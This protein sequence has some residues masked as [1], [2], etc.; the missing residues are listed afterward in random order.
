Q[1]IAESEGKPVGVPAEYDAFHYQH[2]MP[3]GMLSNFQAQL[4]AAGLSHKFEELLEECAAVRRELAWPI[5]ITPFSQFVG[6][7]AVMNIVHGER[8]AIVPDEVK[9]YALGYYGKLLGPVDP[10]ALD[11][12]VRNGSPKIPLIPPPLEPLVAKARSKYP[13]VSDDELLLRLMLPA[14]AVDEMIAAQPFDT[15]Y[16]PTSCIVDLV[17]E[18]AKRK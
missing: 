12:I 7:Q 8:Y 3:G 14:K 9:K 10:N 6:T 13:S 2:Q 4:A 18:V 17:R 15:Q 11:R 1:R 16:R 5:M